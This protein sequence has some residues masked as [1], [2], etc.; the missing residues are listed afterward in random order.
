[1]LNA[2]VS[3]AMVTKISTLGVLTLQ[4]K[5]LLHFDEPHMKR[6]IELHLSR[7]Q[8][9]K[10]PPNPLKCSDVVVTMETTTRVSACRIRGRTI[11]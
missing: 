5:M 10:E 3:S 1:M 6:G 8:Q 4:Y 9:T 11:F 2:K 7:V